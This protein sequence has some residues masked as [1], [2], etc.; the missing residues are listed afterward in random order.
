M[1]SCPEAGPRCPVY[2]LDLYI[3]KLPKGAKEKDLV[4]VQPLEK[5]PH[6]ASKLWY[7]A[8]P[9]GNHTLQQ[10]IKKM[11]SDAGIGGLKMNHSLR[12]TGATELFKRGAPKKLI[13]EQTRHR[14]LGAL[15]IYERLS[16]EQHKAV[17]TLLSTPDPSH[18]TQAIEIHQAAPST[19]R[20]V[21]SMP[22]SFQNLQGCTINI[23]GSPQFE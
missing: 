2:L 13:Q 3:S 11:C 19:Q 23:I 4:Y 17:S 14:S 21:S 15:R 6:D 12:A 18:L 22:V 1:Y 20:S 8:V 7:S 9:V 10:M 16:E 5:L